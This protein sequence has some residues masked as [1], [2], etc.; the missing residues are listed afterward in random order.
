M[1]FLTIKIILKKVRGN[2]VDISTS[3][4]NQKN[5]WKRRG[6]L[7]HWNYIKKVYANDV[8]IRRNLVFNKST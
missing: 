2:N 6:F 3:E 8:E 1:D 7:D 4:I 5:T